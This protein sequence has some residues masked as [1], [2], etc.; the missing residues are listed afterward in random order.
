MIPR[1]SIAPPDRQIEPAARAAF[2]DALS[3]NGNGACFNFDA[4]DAMCPS[5]KVTRDRRH[6]PKGRAGLVREWLRLLARQGVDP[7]AG[8][9]EPSWLT[10][11]R[12]AWHSLRARCGEPDFSHEVKAAMD[13]CLACKSCV[14]QCPVKVDVPAFRA[15]FLAAYH[16]RYLRPPRDW[17]LSLLESLLPVA[18]YVPALYNGVVS[19]G[20]GRMLLRSCGLVA[21]PRLTGLRPEPSLARLGVKTATPDAIGRLSPEERGRSLV[22]VQ[23]AFTG[24]FETRLLIDL[25]RVAQALGYIPWLAPYKPNGKPLHVT[26]R[27]AAFAR[28]AARN[29][30]MLK[31][32]ETSGV[33]LVGLDPS[34]TLTY[35][36]E[37]R[38]ALG[39]AA[40]QVLLPQEW[41]LRALAGR[42]RPAR[43]G[44]EFQ[45]LPHCTERTNAGSAADD[46]KSVFAVFGA[47]LDILPSGCCGMAGTYGHEA[48]KRDLSERIYQMSWAPIVARAGRQGRLMATGYSCR[49]QAKLIDAIELKHPIQ[50][51][52]ALVEAGSGP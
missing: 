50:V 16:G 49:S 33:P 29:A 48:T 41:L 1:L 51:L 40:P 47:R 12:R 24:Y 23:D 15:R 25:A 35:R 6:S 42:A 34:M 22:L 43:L 3:C 36:S 26:G 21:T 38:S 46:W 27:L 32:L 18:A 44:R 52:T 10:L 5:W 37:Y 7:S 28:A 19:S 20:P 45:L 9:G 11:P 4:D 31:A 2:G 8:H 13:G 39:E 14:G 30:A 17:L